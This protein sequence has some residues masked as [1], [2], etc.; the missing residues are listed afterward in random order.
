MTNQFIL[1]ARNFSK[2]GSAFGFSR[3]IA[4]IPSKKLALALMMQWSHTFNMDKIQKVKT[5]DQL[6]T[7]IGAKAAKA[8]VGESG[9]EDGDRLDNETYVVE[10]GDGNGIDVYN[11]LE[12]ETPDAHGIRDI[13]WNTMFHFEDEDAE[14]ETARGDAIGQL[15]GCLNGIRELKAS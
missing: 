7:C 15:C 5:A 6:E 11:I 10:D 14:D 8:Y 3:I 9:Y 13:E 1:T 4:V 12:V 2:P